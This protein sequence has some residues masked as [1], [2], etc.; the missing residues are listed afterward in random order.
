MDISQ[1][2]A[3]FSSAFTQDNRLLTLSLG[4]GSIAAE[5]LLPQALEGEEGV[6]ES[7]R[8]QLICLSPNGSIELKSLLGVAAKIGIAAASG[9]EL[10]RCGVVANRLTAPAGS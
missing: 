2:L 9:E 3:S 5:T 4:D 7:Y 10:V 8:Y 1:L 6:S